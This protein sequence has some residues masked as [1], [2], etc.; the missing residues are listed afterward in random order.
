MNF[1]LT[2]ER[3]QLQPCRRE[4]LTCL[5][6]LWTA[7]RV[8]DFLFDDRIIGLDE[9]Q[10]FIETSLDS[11]AQHQY[12]LWIVSTQSQCIGFAGFLPAEAAPNLI[13]GIHPDFWGQG[14]A[15]EAARAVLR[16]GLQT[17]ALPKVKADVD[18]PNLASVQVLQKLGMQQV[19]QAIVHDRSLLYFES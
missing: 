18:E 16:Y 13:Y 4:D 3:L 2:T 8:R 5:Y 12:G 17:L 6:T 7:D 14:Y 9:A 15:T 11:F 10:A 19:G 1:I